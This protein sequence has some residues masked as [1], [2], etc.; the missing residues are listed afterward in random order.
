MPSAARCCLPQNEQ[1]C[2]PSS[3][4]ACS[5]Y[6]KVC[7]S[8][9]RPPALKYLYG[10][11]N[12]VRECRAHLSTGRGKS[13]GLHLDR[14]VRSATCT[15]LP[16]RHGADKHSTPRGRLQRGHSCRIGHSRLPTHTCLCA[17]CVPSRMQSSK[18]GNLGLQSHPIA[19]LLQ[20]LHLICLECCHGYTLASVAELATVGGSSMTSDAGSEG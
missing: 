4:C 10:S 2:G 20:S 5:R 8:S 3:C 14:Y 17:C 15:A 1:S 6:H 7:L 12:T 11:C 18:G 9:M 16:C 13:E 19:C